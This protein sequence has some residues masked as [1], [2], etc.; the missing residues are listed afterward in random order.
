MSEG[1]DVTQALTPHVADSETTEEEDFYGSES[2]EVVLKTP[3]DPITRKDIR[4]LI[5]C[6]EEKSKKITERVRA[7]EIGTHDVHAHMDVVMRENR[8]C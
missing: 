6:W 1:G 2:E 3:Q 4:E 7:L 8:A 5:N